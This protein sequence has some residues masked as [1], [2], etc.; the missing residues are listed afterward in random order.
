M[1]EGREKDNMN[2]AYSR[3]RYEENGGGGELGSTYMYM[4][5]CSVYYEVMYGLNKLK[6]LCLYTNVSFHF[7]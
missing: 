5:Y 2:I 4:Y 1:I 7:V 3:R 6:K